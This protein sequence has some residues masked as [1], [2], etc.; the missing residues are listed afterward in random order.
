MKEKRKKYKKIKQRQKITK[1]VEAIVK[2]WDWNYV[3][4]HLSFLQFLNQI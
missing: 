2:G 1:E 3:V 4:V